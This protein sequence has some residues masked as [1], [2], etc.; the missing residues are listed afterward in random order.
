VQYYFPTVSD[1]EF[2]GLGDLP[3]SETWINGYLQTGLIAHE[4]G[5]NLGVH[6]AGSVSCADGSGAKVAVSTSC[7]FSEYGDPFDAM[8][9]GSKLMSSWHRAQLGQLPAA[10]RRTVT[11]SGSYDLADANDFTTGGSKLLLIPRKRAGQLTTDFYAL[12]IRRPLLP[13]DNWTATQPQATGV[14]IRLVPSI[15]AL[16]QS[17]LIDNVPATP[18]VTDAPLQPGRTFS[19]PGYGIEIGAPAAAAP[20]VWRSPCPSCRTRRRPRRRPAS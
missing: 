15:T 18:E 8:G 12:E 14:S 1:C 5:H 10:N 16:L 20:P 7:T 13:F 11:T 17:R 6:H 3:G 19:D 9:R 4:L 2:G